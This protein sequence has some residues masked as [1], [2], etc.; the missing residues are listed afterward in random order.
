MLR[1]MR[2]RR[3]RGGLDRG[4]VQGFGHV[5]REDDQLG[6]ESNTSSVVTM[7]TFD[8]SPADKLHL[9]ACPDIIQVALLILPFYSSNSFSCCDPATGPPVHQK[10]RFS[11]LFFRVGPPPF[12]FDALSSP[13]RSVSASGVGC[14]SFPYPPVFL[15]APSLQTLKTTL[16]GNTHL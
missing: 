7:V 1:A 14:R 6:I 8:G 16:V 13:F 5:I 4:T 9:I 15:I 3:R 12:S 2:R 10:K 11:R